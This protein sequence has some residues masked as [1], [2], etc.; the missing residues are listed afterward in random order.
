[1][2][3]LLVVLAVGAM[4]CDRCRDPKAKQASTV[5]TP[6]RADAR[7]ARRNWAP[8]PAPSL[9]AWSAAEAAKTAEAW[10]R[11][12]DEYARARERCV[13]DCL[14]AAYAVVLA[15]KNAL[16]ADPIKPPKPEESPPLPARVKALV[17]ALD[18]YLKIAPPTDPDQLDMKFL[19][20]NAINLWHQEDAVARLEELLREHRNDPSAEYV[21]NMLLDALMRANRVEELKRWVSEL[22][23]D[24]TF[25]EGKDQLRSTLETVRVQLA[26]ASP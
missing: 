15:R 24:A 8:P 14:D 1:M 20:A 11:A 6:Q 16:S 4:S 7:T 9:P 19:A 2:H 23:A 26:E 3:Y 18:D 5:A 12:A 25:L 21:V 17:S 22:L 10:D 13:D